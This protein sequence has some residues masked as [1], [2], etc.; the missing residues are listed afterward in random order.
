MDHENK[1][2]T[3]PVYIEQIPISIHDQIATRRVAHVPYQSGFL[4]T[5]TKKGI[6]LLRTIQEKETLL[7]EHIGAQRKNRMK[8]KAHAQWV[9]KKSCNTF[10]AY[11][12]A[13][14]SQYLL[15][16]KHAEFFYGIALRY[17]GIGSRYTGRAIFD[18]SDQ[19]LDIRPEEA[20]ITKPGQVSGAHI[21]ANKKLLGKTGIFLDAGH[22]P[23][24]KIPIGSAADDDV[25]AIERDH[26]FLKEGA[27]LSVV[28]VDAIELL[29]KTQEPQLSTDKIFV[30][31]GILTDTMLDLDYTTTYPELYEHFATSIYD[32]PFEQARI[33]HLEELSTNIGK[34]LRAALDLGYTTTHRSK[35]TKKDFSF[36]GGLKDT[37]ELIQMQKPEDAL[38]II[39]MYMC[40]IV[41]TLK[42]ANIDFKQYIFTNSFKEFLKEFFDFES[43]SQAL[44]TQQNIISEFIHA[45]DESLLLKLI[46]SLYCTRRNIKEGISLKELTKN[47]YKMDIQFALLHRDILVA[48]GAEARWAS[49]Y[50]DDLEITH[51]ES[52]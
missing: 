36:F 41:Y 23:H 25:W 44:E 51:L 1:Q 20:L 47:E 17:K 22:Q 50:E 27:E 39:T 7:A 29:N 40:D 37:G 30:T 48:C 3:L 34:N 26:E 6:N 18:R 42:A 21:T 4:A 5:R 52:A 13:E 45:P 43:D 10:L 38:N 8:E 49:F 35:P 16:H 33:K 11:W 15:T 46:A 12:N 14:T 28:N 24:S 31:I 19:P 32:L 2:M 9:K